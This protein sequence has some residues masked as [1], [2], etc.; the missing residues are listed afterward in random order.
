MTPGQGTEQADRRSADGV[1]EQ[2]LVGLPIVERRMT[3]AGISTAVLE[4]GQGPSIVLLHSSGEFAALWLRVIPDLVTTH[5]VIAPDLPGHG[6]S[7]GADGGLDVTSTLAWVSE[8]IDRT[9]SSPP[10]L[11]GH[12]LGGAIAARFAGS[13]GDR[14]SRLVLVDSLGLGPLE[15]EPSFQLAATRFLEGPT[16]RTRDDLFRRCFVDL[17]GLREQMG[18]RWEAIAAYALERVRTPAMS[19]ALGNLMPQFGGEIPSTDLVRIA[20][21]T[22]LIWGRH[23]LQV[24]VR[25]AAAASAR[26]GWP[27]HVIDDAGD[28]PAMEKPEAFIEALR[29]VLAPVKRAEA[30]S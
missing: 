17:D 6:A 11:I 3:L 4:G 25:I 8:L 16:E 27:L 15:P 24:P 5:R 14:L 30:T 1:R 12:A 20:V 2:M 13:H 18:E 7:A 28:D 29:A 23:D 22:A 10:A 19:A 26:H 21:P 9:C